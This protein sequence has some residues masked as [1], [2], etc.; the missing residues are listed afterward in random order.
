MTK[1]F[2][3]VD[4]VTGE[5]V[6]DKTL[7]INY[8]EIVVPP[9]LSQIISLQPVLRLPGDSFPNRLCSHRFENRLLSPHFNMEN[10]PEEC[11]YSACICCYT[12]ARTP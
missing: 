7:A 12:C 10:L 9:A 8:S 2:W 4:P 3:P 6:A 5:S 1:R 11:V